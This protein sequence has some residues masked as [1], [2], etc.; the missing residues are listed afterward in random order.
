MPNCQF[1]LVAPSFPIV[2]QSDFGATIPWFLDAP[3]DLIYDI[4]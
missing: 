1:R 4:S 2:T 3:Y